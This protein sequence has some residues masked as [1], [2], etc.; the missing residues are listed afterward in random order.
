MAAEGS[1]SW[2]SDV[3]NAAAIEV[4]ALTNACS[5]DPYERKVNLSVGGKSFAIVFS[6]MVM[7]L[8]L[9]PMFIVQLKDKV[10]V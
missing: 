10:K 5:K 2:F 9:F 6:T 3:Q 4:F 1:N 7:L 8:V